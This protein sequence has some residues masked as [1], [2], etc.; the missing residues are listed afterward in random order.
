M[1][2]NIRMRRNRRNK[3]LRKLS[4][5]TVVTKDDLIMPFFIVKGR[6][7]KEPIQ[8][9]PGVF[10]MSTDHVIQTLSDCP[11]RAVLLFAVP[12][13]DEKDD[14]ASAALKKDGI[15][16]DAIRKIKQACPDLAVITDVCLCAYT[17]HGHCG[18][19]DSGRDVD[20]D[21]SIKLLAQ[22]AVVHAQAGADMVA[23]SAMMDGQVLAIR[24]ALDD[25]GFC[26]TAI[27]SYAAKFASSFYGPFRD[28]AQAAPG[29][30]NRSSYQL[31]MTNRKEA[32][33]DA[34]LDEAEGADW[35]MVKPAMPYLDVLRDLCCHSRL[36]VAAYQVSGEY[37]MLKHASQAGAFD[38]KATVLESIICLKRAGARA[39]ITY[40]VKEICSWLCQ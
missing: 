36:P 18:L 31:P 37:A 35:L 1:Y 32:I 5:E 33:R 2:P 39:I 8:S 7:R 16:P 6:D 29:F 24:N 26:D 17:S 11:V 10:R 27:M 28:A 14:R 15:V 23:P 40:Y 4:E 38:E 3:A 21:A 20:N 9:M 25:S 12:E 30:G 13:Q 19:L 34:L 22:M